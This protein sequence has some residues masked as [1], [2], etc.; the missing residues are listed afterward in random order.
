V[1]GEVR[2]FLIVRVPKLYVVSIGDSTNPTYIPDIGKFNDSVRR[3][4]VSTIQ[5]VR[6]IW[7]KARYLEGDGSSR[8]KKNTKGEDE[9]WYK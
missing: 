1:G 7:V 6:H 3:H 2:E 5:Y 4:C 8:G 9:K